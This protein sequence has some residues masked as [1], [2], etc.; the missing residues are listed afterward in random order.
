MWCVGVPLPTT[1]LILDF[2]S[3]QCFYFRDVFFL[4]SYRSSGE[5]V[6]TQENGQKV[7][8]EEREKE[9]RS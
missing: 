5:K 6:R 9:D 7:V 4:F 3:F 8:V 1:S 2:F